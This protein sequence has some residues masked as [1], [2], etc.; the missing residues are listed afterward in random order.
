MT[1]DRQTTRHSRWIVGGL[2]LLTAV[3]HL[4]GALTFLYTHDEVQVIQRALRQVQ[5]PP[6]HGPISHVVFDLPLTSSNAVTP[7]WLWIQASN[8]HLTP[9][10]PA[11]TRLPAVIFSL[12]AVVL[13]FRLTRPRFGLAVATLTGLAF[14]L[15]D[16]C[17]WTGAKSEFTEP[18]L[19]VV[20]LAAMGWML[21]QDLRRFTTGAMI[22]SLAPLTYLGKGLFLYAFVGLW[23]MAIAAERLSTSHQSRRLVVRD[24]SRRLM[25]LAASLLPTLLWLIAAHLHLEM[26]RA[27][28]IVLTG[29]LGPIHSLFEQVQKTTFGYFEQREFLHGNWRTMLIV[30]THLAAW[31]TSTLMAPWALIGLAIGIRRLGREPCPRARALLLALPTMGFAPFLYLLLRGYEGGRF[32]LLYQVPF[33]LAV[34]LAI[35]TT[36]RWL[37]S[38]SS[39]QRRTGSLTVGAVGLYLAG[40]T[41]M[42]SWASWTFD[43]RQLGLRAVVIVAGVAAVSAIAS[44][45][46]SRD[47]AR[48]GNSSRLV[49]TLPLTAYLLLLA[50]LMLSHGPMLWGRWQGWGVEGNNAAGFEERLQATYPELQNYL[51]LGP[52]IN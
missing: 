30:Y 33:A 37:V 32:T 3:L 14:A 23:L 28:G 4:L 16:L 1:S 45:L 20:V 39:M 15:S 22:L 11:W 7:L 29:D 44:W 2:V 49:A 52:A 40:I 34:G 10:H 13:A 46:R 43:G 19:L 27:S 21:H 48:L 17:L 38:E 24:L 42:T 51:T 31:P 47:A 9:D 25:I 50:T 8:A 12:L 26:L 36:G 18:L 5:A 41:S 35:A 6:L